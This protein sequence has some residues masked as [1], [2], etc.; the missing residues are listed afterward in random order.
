MALQ[1]A[2]VQSATSLM[3]V[4]NE[5]LK[6]PQLSSYISSQ[7]ALRSPTLKRAR[8]NTAPTTPMVEAPTREPAEL[9][10]SAPQWPRS[11]SVGP[12]SMDGRSTYSA[13]AS[14]SA[15]AMGRSIER[16]HSSQDS[17]YGSTYARRST[18]V[19]R[20][21]MSHYSSSENMSR[22]KMSSPYKQRSYG[23]GFGTGD[24]T[25]IGLSS[26]ADTTFI[27]RPADNNK[28]PCLTPVPYS[29]NTYTASNHEPLRTDGSMTVATIPPDSRDHDAENALITQVS[30]MR[31]VHEA[32]IESLKEA[33]ERELDSFRA[34]LAFLEQRRPTGTAAATPRPPSTKPPTCETPEPDTAALPPSEGLSSATS[35]QSFDTAL[36]VQPLS[37]SGSPYHGDAA[38]EIEA[39]R[40][41]LSLFRK[42]HADGTDVRRER[43][44]LRETAENAARRHAQ[45]KELLRKAKDNDKT[46]RGAIA[47]LEGRLEAANN[48]RT[49]LL[50]GLDDAMGKLARL[51]AREDEL[52]RD[53][54]ELSTRLFYA[55]PSWDGLVLGRTVA[56]PEGADAATE[57]LREEIRN[58]RAA[59][60][61][62]DARIA[63][64]EARPVDMV[65]QQLLTPTVTPPPP[66]AAPRP[67]MSNACTQ[68]EDLGDAQEKELIAARRATVSS[69]LENILEREVREAQAKLAQ[70]EGERDR[71]DA[72]LHTEL[73]R[74]LR[75]A[76]KNATSITPQIATETA[77]ATAERMASLRHTST[78]SVVTAVNTAA[79]PEGAAAA[80]EKE[81]EHCVAEIIMYKLDIKGYKK[82][83]RRANAEIT[84]LRQSVAAAAASHNAGS[85]GG[86]RPPTPDSGGLPRAVEEEK[87]SSGHRHR[88]HHHHH[89]HH[90]SCQHH[91]DHKKATL[92]PSVVAAATASN[93]SSS[94]ATL[95][96]T[97]GGKPRSRPRP[98]TIDHGLG[99]SLLPTPSPSPRGG[100]V[101]L[102]ASAPAKSPSALAAVPDHN[103]RVP[104]A[105]PTIG[106][107]PATPRTGVQK[108]LP[109]APAPSPPPAV[110]AALSPAASASLAALTQAAADVGYTVS[111]I[112]PV[113]AVTAVETATTA[114]TAAAAP[115]AKVS[116]IPP[117]IARV[118]TM[119]SLSESILSSYAKRGD[120]MSPAMGPAE[121]GG[122]GA[123]M[124][125]LEGSTPPLPPVAAGV[126]RAVVV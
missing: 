58:L 92:S 78:A 7:H 4:V 124:S 33:H 54:E 111:P 45:L 76:A 85:G 24:N 3:A 66:A 1:D 17:G 55:D 2:A 19:S 27:N 62:K 70:V 74:Q 44:L 119:R 69:V 34:Y 102:S 121:G 11:A 16:P 10:G 67:P 5:M 23:D 93:F 88:H 49:D 35:H 89:R 31:A 25:L 90:H 18:D 107:V 125:E 82:D 53:R 6:S 65:A 15:S 106:P 60:L 52:L 26:I 22:S 21:G 14:S 38:T 95:S 56:T 122:E 115:R 87:V 64:L 61:E 123:M 59:A 46:L 8:S 120:E 75:Q 94:S 91:R 81:L 72:L 103:D 43:D 39:L 83:L 32:H 20:S 57:A 71:L 96:P 79:A 126:G 110:A 99:I 12:Y 101:H 63:E 13:A 77:A 48:A 97:G 104:A 41:K 51:S 118:E 37:R 73:R 50:E 28:T 29:A 30:T 36:E 116:P 84:D 42:A 86:N 47:D 9:P 109:R 105:V 113:S 112:S 108:R 100:I 40:R 68:T 98:A 114:A 117:R 80:L